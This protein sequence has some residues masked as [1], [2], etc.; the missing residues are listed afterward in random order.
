MMATV[1]IFHSHHMS[2]FKLLVLI[3][4]RVSMQSFFLFFVFSSF[5]FFAISLFPVRRAN[6]ACVTF[7]QI[8]HFGCCFPSLKGKK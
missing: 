5:F 1:V 3:A 8:C 7:V 4:S 6:E 2:C